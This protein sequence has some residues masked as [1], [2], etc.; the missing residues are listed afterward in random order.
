M[1]ARKSYVSHSTTSKV[2]ASNSVPLQQQNVAQHECI[3]DHGVQTEQ[4]N[5]KDNSGLIQNILAGRSKTIHF[6]ST[7]F[8]FC[9]FCSFVI[10]IYYMYVDVCKTPG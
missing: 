9:S 1:K 5:I 7:N 6:T 4:I 10:S 8:E 3:E 2:T